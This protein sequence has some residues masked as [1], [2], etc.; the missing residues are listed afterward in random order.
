MSLSTILQKLKQQRNYIPHLIIINIILALFNV[1]VLCFS[2]AVVTDG[3]LFDSPVK[4][5]ISNC[6]EDPCKDC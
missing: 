6:S 2:A 4:E 3:L 5:N 1:L